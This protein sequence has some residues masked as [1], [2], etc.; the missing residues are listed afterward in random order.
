[1]YNMDNLGVFLNFHRFFSVL[2]LYVIH[3][4]AKYVD[5]FT[6]LKYHKSDKMSQERSNTDNAVNRP[7]CFF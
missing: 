7:L 1:M 5:L 3:D 2:A 4:G 6:Q